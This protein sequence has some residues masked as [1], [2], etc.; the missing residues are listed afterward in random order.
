[1]KKIGVVLSMVMCVVIIGALSLTA[2]AENT[3]Y[4][5]DELNMSVAVPNDMIAITRE[6]EKTDSFFSKFGV[7]YNETMNNLED[8]DIYLYAL[9][10]DNSLSLTVTMT[11]NEESRKIDSYSKISDEEL[12]KIKDELLLDKAYKTST[13]VDVKGTKYILLTMSQKSGKKIIQAQQYNTVINGENII[14]TMQSAAGK[15]LTSDHKELFAS[16]IE[17]TD[18]IEENFFTQ[19]RDLIIYGSAT[20][21]G[22]IIVAVVLILLLRYFRNP[23]RR[24]KHLV[25]ELAHEHRITDTT[26]IP[27]KNI[28]NITKPTQS[29]LENYDPIEEL[30]A[31]PKRRRKSAPSEAQ[32]AVSVS[33]AVYEDTLK[34][35]DEILPDDKPAV[36]DT[37]KVEK[38]L[39]TDDLDRAVSD[40]IKAAQ[41]ETATAATEERNVKEEEITAETDGQNA[42]E[43]VDA[44]SAASEN[45]F[46]SPEDYF[47]YSSNED[48]S[49]L[50]TDVQESFGDYSSES[51]DYDY[52][53]NNDMP[54][55]SFGENASRVLKKIGSVLSVIGRGIAS[56]AGTVW[57]VI[58]YIIIHCR[59]FCINLYR[60]IKRRHNIRK[61]RKIEEER[62][63]QQ[64]ERRRMEREAERARQ[65]QNAARGENDLVKVHS[66]G[67]RRPVNRNARPQQRV[68]Y[69]RNRAQDQRP[70]R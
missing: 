43:V 63:R 49:D 17:G 19:Y 53:S 1:M 16:I 24:H 41:E 21:I 70:R 4:E 11:E 3:S 56:V 32:T 37:V 67:E 64:S 34:S 54:S 10:E 39:K 57:T 18:I 46:D 2:F 12:S 22:V 69:P 14:L 40:A 48:S 52:E 27:K 30:G 15:N 62:R 31:K 6:S 68:A 45:A 23:Q 61:R 55:Q 26:Q 51:G 65:R 36:Q 50:F 66:R 5:L 38:T 44:A 47:D 42:Q 59:Y 29:F 13:V 60:L 9:K 20:L 28:F 7:D 58:V 35:L 25:H 8:G 33:E